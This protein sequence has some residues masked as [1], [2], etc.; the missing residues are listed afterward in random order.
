MVNF[1]QVMFFIF[2]RFFNLLYTYFNRKHMV[3]VNPQGIEILIL[4]REK[5]KAK[6]TH[7][8]HYNF[9]IK[10]TY[11]HVLTPIKSHSL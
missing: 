1:L 7:N 6:N 8:C 4:I 11:L 5:Y 3:H 2:V 9:V 10:N